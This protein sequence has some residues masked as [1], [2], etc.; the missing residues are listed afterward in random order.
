MNLT[1]I[2]WSQISEEAEEKIEKIGTRIGRK[3]EGEYDEG[4]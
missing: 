3:I 1:R 2:S 4:Y